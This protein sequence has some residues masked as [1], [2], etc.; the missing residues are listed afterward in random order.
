MGRLIDKQIDLA[1]AEAW[2]TGAKDE[3][4]DIRRIADLAAVGFQTC[5]DFCSSRETVG[6]HRCRCIRET[7]PTPTHYELYLASR[8]KYKELFA[9]GICSAVL[10]TSQQGEKDND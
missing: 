10:A 7:F 6:E 2:E 3:G 1:E 8:S 4:I 9:I 5:E